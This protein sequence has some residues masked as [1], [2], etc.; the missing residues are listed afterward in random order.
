M[1][2]TRSGAIFRANTAILT[3]SSRRD[4]YPPRINTSSTAHRDNRDE[5]PQAS[6]HALKCYYPKPAC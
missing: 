1:S 6:G 5:I 3:A 2:C 4:V